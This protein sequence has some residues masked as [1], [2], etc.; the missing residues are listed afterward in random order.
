MLCPRRDEVPEN[1]RWTKD[2]E[3]RH[4]DTC[5][6]CGSLNPDLFMILLREGVPLGT[7]TK[8]YKA[9]IGDHRKFYYQH[10]TDEQRAEF[11]QMLNRDMIKFQSVAGD[12]LSFGKWDAPLPYFVQVG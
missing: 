5:S 1:L 4:D 7:T 3:W 10:M 9:Y 2:D 11:I 8:N 12:T 6:F